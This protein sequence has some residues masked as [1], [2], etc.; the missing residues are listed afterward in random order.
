MGD[1]FNLK[2]RGKYWDA[3]FTL[4]GVRVHR[5]TKKTIKADALERCETWAQEILDR[6]DG[7]VEIP[8]VEVPTLA[9]VLAEWSRLQ[10]KSV[11]AAYMSHMRVAVET[12]AVKYL[13]TPVDQIDAAVLLEIRAAYLQTTGRGYRSGQ[14]WESERAHTAG[15]A[16]SVMRRLRALLG[17]YAELHPAIASRPGKLKNLKPQPKPEGIVWPEQVQAFLAEADRGGFDWAS[18]K[19]SRVRPHSAVA[20][21]LMLGL[22]LREAEALGAR[23]EWLDR[24]RSVYVVGE[25]KDRALREIP[26]PKWLLTFLDD[27]PGDRE[28]G[29]ILPS[30][31]KDRPHFR[32]F[33][34]KPVDR[35][36]E[37]LKI[38]GLT[39]HRLRATFATTHFE[40]GTPLSQI[41][42]M[43]GH[44]D[45]ATTFE[46]YI[47]QRPVGQAEAQ[48]RVAALQGFRSA[49]PKITLFFKRRFVNRFLIKLIK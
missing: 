23:W 13:G 28:E 49:P 37:K 2:K 8:A 40:V 47:V 14:K 7:K 32:N 4:L 21:R 48:D 26:V 43:M 39:P 9:D 33:T 16:N 46:R 17:W 29:L 35:I 18:R 11:S 36:A 30:D 10:A 3:D 44:E 41:A 12:H 5:S 22:G 1:S 6:A 34:K 31:G 45:P 42:Q 27:L 15:G 19:P 38:S 25:A 20:I 24:R